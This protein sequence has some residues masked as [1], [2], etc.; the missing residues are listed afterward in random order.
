MFLVLTLGMAVGGPDP[1]LKWVR[2]V[3]CAETAARAAV[4]VLTSLPYIPSGA[5]DVSPHMW[6]ALLALGENART[7]EVTEVHVLLDNAT[8]DA[9][10][11][12]RKDVAR[13]QANSPQLSRAANGSELAKIRAHVFG[14]QPTYVE[15]LRYA[16]DNL[17]GLVALA[18]ADVVLRNLDQIDR[19]AFDDEPPLV[20]ALSVSL[21]NEQYLKSCGDDS[22]LHAKDELVDRC[23]KYVLRG[24]SWDTYVFKS[25]L[26]PDACYDLFTSEPLPIYMNSMGAENRAG[27]F[28]AVSG[29]HLYNPCQSVVVEHWHCAPKMHGRDPPTGKWIHPGLLRAGTYVAPQRVSRGI[30]CD[31][32]TKGGPHAQQLPRFVRSNATA[33]CRAAVADIRRLL[34]MSTDEWR[35]EGVGLKRAIREYDNRREAGN[36]VGDVE[37]DQFGQTASLTL[38]DTELLR[39]DIGRGVPARAEEPLRAPTSY[40]DTAADCSL[41]SADPT[42]VTLVTALPP[43][44]GGAHRSEELL[45][46]GENARNALVAAIHVFVDEDHG[47]REAVEREQTTNRHRLEGIGGLDKITAVASSRASYA[48]LFRYASQDEFRGKLV[49]VANPDVVLRNLD[50]LDATAFNDENKLALAVSTTR[51]HARY[52]NGCKSLDGFNLGDIA[53]YVQEALVDTCTEWVDRGWSWNVEIFK[54]P[55]RASHYDPLEH[56]HLTSVNGHSQVGHFLAT[57]G[58]ELANP[59]ETLRMEEWRC[60]PGPGDLHSAPSHDRHQH[61]RVQVHQLARY[62]GTFVAP[63]VASR[64]IRCVR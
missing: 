7:P 24:W 32:T 46:L 57:S 63:C 36:V 53:H 5:R 11:A 10:S 45:A 34:Q 31:G 43:G 6:E 52:L 35:D 26:V 55:I 40:V 30:R 58:Y 60:E 42:T 56:V 12:L 13:C 59:C 1:R 17:Q 25:P 20:F 9:T 23:N 41:E 2:E 18:N 16:N 29:Y 4:T 19:D 49:A 47:L 44:N 37:L 22:A 38:F 8:G 33:N 61:L 21:P 64:G 27:H 54:S 51:P 3:A 15:L 50:A 39:A 14:H 48:D 28:F 62:N